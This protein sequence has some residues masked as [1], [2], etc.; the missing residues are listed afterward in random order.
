MTQIPYLTPLSDAEQRAAGL[1]EIW[2]LALA[3]RVRFSELDPLNHVNNVAYLIW[4]ETARVSYFK[5]INL[6]A[7][8]NAAVEPRIVIRHGEMEWLQEMRAD[9]DYVIVSKTIAY[10]NTSFTMH[11]EIWSGGTKRA[12]F[13]CVIVLLQ[14]DGSGRFPLPEPLKAHFHTVDGVPVAQE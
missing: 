6:S 5:Q 12:A 14:P 2:P 11:Q 10:R 1:P 9:E 7:Y 4:F 3:D 13:T 8:K